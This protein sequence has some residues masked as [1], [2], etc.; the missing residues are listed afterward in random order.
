MKTGHNKLAGRMN[1]TIGFTGVGIDPKD[2]RGDGN[3]VISPAA[4]YELPVIVQVIN[5]LSL[6]PADKTAFKQALFVF[7]IG[8]G[9][10]HFDRITLVGDSINLLGHGRVKFDGD[11]KLGFVSS[12]GRHSVPI[13]FVRDV[14]REMTKGVVGVNVSGTL[15]APVTEVRSLPQ[16]EEGLRRLF[17]NRGAQKR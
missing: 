15:D 2:L 1:G 16:M 9:H 10:V 3:L 14:V 6:T 11:V 8:G 5:V 13:P 4:L 17:D 7:N 12:M